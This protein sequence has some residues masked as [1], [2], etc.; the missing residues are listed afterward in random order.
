MASIDLQPQ[1]LD[2]SLYAGDGCRFKFI[3]T[4]ATSAPVDISGGVR[5]QIRLNR[6]DT[7]PVVSFAVNMTDAYLGIII[8][9]LTG[10]QTQALVGSSGKFTGFWDL[11]WDAAEDEPRT[12]CQGRVECVADVTR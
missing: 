12:L 10:A 2:L 5:A 11:E 4:D 9:T 3:C 7:S 8:L 1:T 6:L